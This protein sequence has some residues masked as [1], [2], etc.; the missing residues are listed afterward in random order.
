MHFNVCAPWEATRQ[1]RGVT[2]L[3]I[4]VAT[5]PDWVQAMGD[6]YV[7]LLLAIRTALQSSPP[8]EQGGDLAEKRCKL[9]SHVRH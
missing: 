7:D 5:Y 1:H 6:P 4:D 9:G 3:L 8:S 2:D